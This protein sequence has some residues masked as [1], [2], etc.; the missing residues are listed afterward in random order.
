MAGIDD[1]NAAIEEQYNAVLPVLEDQEQAFNALRDEVANGASR[2]AIADSISRLA[3]STNKIREGIR[4]LADSP[5]TPDAGEVVVT[6]LPEEPPVVSEP[7]ENGG[8]PT[9]P[10]ED[11]GNVPEGSDPLQQ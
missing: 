11:T 8:V 1:L 7:Q 5:S 10:G 6:P 4:S 2:E 3:V 9:T